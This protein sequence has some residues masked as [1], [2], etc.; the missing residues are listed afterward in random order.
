VSNTRPLR[1]QLGLRF[2]TGNDRRIHGRAEGFLKEIEELETKHPIPLYWNFPVAPVLEKQSRAAANLVAAI[3]NRVRAGEDRI[4]PSGFTLAAHPLL[5]PEELDR[6]L[7]WCYRNPWFPALKRLFDADPEAILPIYPDLYSEALSN[8]YSRHGF[9][10]IGIPI[11]LYRLSPTPGKARWTELK[12]LAGSEYAIRGADSAVRLRPI[13]VLHAE[14]VRPEAIDALLSACGRAPSLTVMLDLDGGASGSASTASAALQRLLSLVA[15]HRQIEFLP[16]SVEAGESAPPEADPGQLLTFVAPI[17]ECPQNRIWDQVEHSRQKKRKNNLQIKELLNSIAAAVPAG[18]TG[19]AGRSESGG[20]DTIEV[21]NISMAGSVSLVGMG[22][23]ATFHQ[24]RLSNLIDRGRELLPGEPGRSVF[25]LG[26]K[27]E[28]LQTE[29]AFSFNRLEQT[30][31]RSILSLRQGREGKGVQVTL[32]YYFSDEDR[33]LILDVTALYP[34]LTDGI[35]S[36]AAPLEI[37]L[38]SFTED[39][40]PAFSVKKPMTDEHRGTVAPFPG[41]FVLWGKR[42][43]FQQG[44]RSVELQPESAHKSRTGKIEFRVEKKR[45]PPRGGAYLLWANLGGSY[46]PQPAANLSA[47]RLKLSYSLGF[48]AG[49]NKANLP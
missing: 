15:R 31:L 43:S 10:T 34:P 36:E 21:T 4:I 7:Q 42:F 24:G 40:C 25:A 8:A 44:K 27:R 6:E 11:P 32:D 19:G 5:L 37:C 29:S 13:V 38:C 22:I 18:T 46:L 48:S 14:E 16:F 28:F 35:V 33:S 30:G 41:V 45:L 3:R 2:G 49:D 47:Q 23:Q 20:T 17:G 39:N 1:L 12:P 9:T 26:N